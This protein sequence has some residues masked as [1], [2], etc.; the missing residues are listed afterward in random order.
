MV[1]GELWA[2]LKP[3]GMPVHP[4]ADSA[5]LDLVSWAVTEAGAPEGLAPIHRLDLG[6]SGLVLLSPD[7]GVRARLGKAFAASGEVRKTYRA[8]VHGRPH[9]KGVVRRAL[10]DP[11]RRKPLPA[12]TRYWR[13]EEFERVTLL[14]VRPETGRRHQIRRHLAGIGHPVVGDTRHGRRSR[15][16]AEAPERLWLHCARLQIPAERLDLRAPLSPELT[17]HLEELRATPPR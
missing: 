2:L 4:G 11:R 16:L 17:A 12:V 3:A 9:K 15:T 6:T 10:P 5:G 8:L 1:K 7:A 13:A 14:R